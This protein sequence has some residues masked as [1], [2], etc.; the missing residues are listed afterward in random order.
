MKVA[1]VHEYLVKLGGAERVLDVLHEIY[2]DAPIFTLLYDEEKTA[3]HYKK[4]WN[5][6]TS[7]LQKMPFATKLIDLY[8][9]FMPL[10]IE[11][12]DLSGFDLVISSSHS[13]AKGAITKP[14]TL[15]IC[16]CYTPTRY[17]WHQMKEGYRHVGNIIKKLLPAGLNYLRVWDQIASDRPDRYVSISKTVQK[18]IKKFYRKDSVIIYPP[19]QLDR[20]LTTNE[21][22]DYFLLVSRLEA[23]KSID[24][25][26][27]AFNS[28]GHKLKIVGTGKDYD[29]LKKKSK[30]NIVFLGRLSDNKLKRL[31][32][33]CKAL[34]FPQEEDFGITVLEA[35]AAG[36]P[37][38]AYARGGA[39]ETVIENMTGIFFK[40][41]TS[42]ELI[43]AIDRFKKKKFSVQKIIQN[44]RRFETKI[45]KK[46]WLKYIK[47]Q[48]AKGKKWNSETM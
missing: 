5:I 25:V 43:D 28:L 31:Y 48:T 29:H 16:Y 22:S 30:P 37:I 11:Q 38:I 1:I 14:G 20:F 12:F 2:P 18:R 8:R 7:F 9:I 21:T 40:K 44:A 46:N 33:R 23:H 19:V 41:Q 35:Q 24:I 36:K 13:F 17:L 47:K 4:G 3:H 26:I 34:I 42:E 45:F 6:K 32:S 39:T 27:D 15:H 10:A